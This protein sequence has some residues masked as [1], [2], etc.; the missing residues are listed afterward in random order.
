M[1]N[2]VEQIGNQRLFFMTNRQAQLLS[3]TSE[4]VDKLLAALEL[5][6]EPKLIII[7][8]DAQR[9]DSDP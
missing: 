9:A 6:A 5:P 3:E 2:M 4:S 7:L 1:Y 8:Q